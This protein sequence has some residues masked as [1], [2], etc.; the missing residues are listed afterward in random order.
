VKTEDKKAA[1]AAYKE[2]KAI[3]GIY[4]VRCLASGKIWIGQST[5]LDTIQNR[6]WFTLRLGNH[7]CRD[8]QQAWNHGT[9]DDFVFEELERME[10]EKLAYVRQARLK[11]RVA[12][13][14]SSLGGAAI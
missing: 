2:R 14:C 9:S 3:V 5:N 8:L 13:W 11:E 10:D 12:Y 7:P 4:A 6:L 1:I